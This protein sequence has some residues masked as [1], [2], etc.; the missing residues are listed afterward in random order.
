MSRKFVIINPWLNKGKNLSDLIKDYVELFDESIKEVSKIIKSNSGKKI[1]NNYLVHYGGLIGPKEDK[2]DIIFMEN[3]DNKNSERFLLIGRGFYKIENFKFLAA[4]YSKN[5]KDNLIV[6]KDLKNGLIFSFDNK[7]K[8]KDLL[9]VILSSKNFKKEGLPFKFITGD[10][11]Y[12][13]YNEKMDMEKI[14]HPF[15]SRKN[16]SLYKG[17][18]ET[19]DYFFYYEPVFL[20]R[21]LPKFNNK[22]KEVEDLYFLGVY[23]KKLDKINNKDQKGIHYFLVSIKNGELK[24]EKMFYSTILEGFKDDFSF[25]AT[26]CLYWAK[27][28]SNPLKKILRLAYIVNFKSDK[29]E[30]KHFV[31]YRNSSIGNY[32]FLDILANIIRIR[33]EDNSITKIYEK[34]KTNYVKNES[35][36]GFKL[37]EIL[38]NYLKINNKESKNYLR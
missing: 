20:L 16:I 35:K 23:Y 34:K 24:N 2:I 26:P 9:Y 25:Y 31:T 32:L 30:A 21:T 17:Y 38:K 11:D 28:A 5:S 7:G 12:F 10:L 6:V 36:S 29:N 13:Y 37:G 27:N 4:T 19:E 8:D 22:K 3:L 1:I 14:E 33:Q 15:L 18:I